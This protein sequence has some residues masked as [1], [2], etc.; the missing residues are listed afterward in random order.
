MD[1]NKEYKQIP[2]TSFSGYRK[3]INFLQGK[4]V[5]KVGFTNRGSCDENMFI[6]TFTDK[7]YIAIGADYNESEF[8]S[9]EPIL[10]NKHISPPQC[11]NGGDYRCHSWVDSSGKLQFDEWINL[12]REC[13][14][15]EFTDEDAQAVMDMKAKD[16]LEREYQNY[17]RL[18]KKFEEN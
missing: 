18:K 5:D 15:W 8:H 16:E 10:D 11:M 3:D 13:G 4:V 2:V 12:L 17:L 6:I 9:D 14:I 7:T 1:I